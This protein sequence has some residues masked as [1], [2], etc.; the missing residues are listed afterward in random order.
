MHA[1]LTLVSRSRVFIRIAVLHG[2]GM[3]IET[4]RAPTRTTLVV[5]TLDAADRAHARAASRIHD[6]RNELRSSVMRG[7]DRVETVM[8]K[9]LARARDV[10]TRA[11]ALGADAVNRA[12][13]AVGAA[14]GRAR[15]D[16]S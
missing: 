13:G 5:R 7:I 14:I 12:Q 15:G 2:V 16:R 3:E 11:D 10:V 4:E 6:V 1:I 9:T 8:T